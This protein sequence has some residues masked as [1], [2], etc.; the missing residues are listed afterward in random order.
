MSEASDNSGSGE[1]S[2]KIPNMSELLNKL[3]RNPKSEREYTEQ[4][5]GHKTTD[6]G[7]V[8]FSSREDFESALRYAQSQYPWLTDEWVQETLEHEDEHLD[9]ARKRFGNKGT[10]NY[11]LQA[12]SMNNGN[13]GIAGG[14]QVDVFGM[15]QEEMDN[16]HKKDILSAAKK[17]SASDKRGTGI[18]LNSDISNENGWK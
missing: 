6:K 4:A 10:Y 17:K 12:I 14:F 11:R 7:E 2:G 15:T 16:Q 18:D 3:F 13:L 5:H 9:E 1:K 8:T